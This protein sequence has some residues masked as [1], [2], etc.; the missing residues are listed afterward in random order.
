MPDRI[1]AAP[2]GQAFGF[3]EESILQL[4]SLARGR[5]IM[6][7]LLELPDLDED[8]VVMLTYLHTTLNEMGKL[9]DSL[10]FGI[11]RCMPNEEPHGALSV[12][13]TGF[14]RP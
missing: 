7:E 3:I 2:A 9:L 6:P 8:D 10:A 5:G 13:L 4:Q 11:E 1:R 14:P 12:E